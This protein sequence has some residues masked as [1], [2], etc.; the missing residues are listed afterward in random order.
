MK[1]VYYIDGYGKEITD[2]EEAKKSL[3]NDY[4]TSSGYCKG[5]ELPLVHISVVT[6]S[7]DNIKLCLNSECIHNKND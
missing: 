4:G 6:I 3:I 1:K 7:N 5:C 2:Y